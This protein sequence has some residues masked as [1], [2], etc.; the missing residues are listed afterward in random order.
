MEAIG[1]GAPIGNISLWKEGRKRQEINNKEKRDFAYHLGERAEE[2]NL[3]MRGRNQGRCGAASSS[4]N[5]DE[6]GKRG[7]SVL[8]YYPCQTRRRGARSL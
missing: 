6:D 1:E 2:W 4:M 7:D 3:S 5:L 8:S